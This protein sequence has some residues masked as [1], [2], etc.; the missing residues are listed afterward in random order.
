MDFVKE[1]AHSIMVVGV[2][3]FMVYF[4]SSRMILFAEICRS[5]CVETTV[6][7]AERSS[8]SWPKMLDCMH[9]HLSKF[10][11]DPLASN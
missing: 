6:E 4:V 1:I 5:L 11:F 2:D 9:E 3:E 10:H 7:M 8:F